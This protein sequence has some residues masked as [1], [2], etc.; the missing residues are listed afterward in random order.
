MA[1]PPDAQKPSRR[2]FLGTT[3]AAGAAIATVGGDAPEA[4]APA[5]GTN[6]PGAPTTPDLLLTN[7]RIHTL[8]GTNRVVSSV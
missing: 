4:Q 3:M 6:A 8:D 5:P 2:H 1:Q 7:G